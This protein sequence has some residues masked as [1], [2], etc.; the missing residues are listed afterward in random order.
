MYICIFKSVW[1]YKDLFIVNMHQCVVNA[2]MNA[3]TVTV[4]QINSMHLRIFKFWVLR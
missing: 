3:H 2:G 1:D 4:L